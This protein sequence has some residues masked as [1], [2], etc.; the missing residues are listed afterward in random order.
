MA[1]S[2]ADKE[3]LALDLFLNTDKPQREICEIVG[4]T[5]KTFTEKKKKNRWDELKSAHTLTANKIISNIYKKL[6]EETE[7]DRLDADK[8][9]KLANSIEKLSD[10][11]ATISQIINVFKEFT[12]FTM[13]L[14]PE[15]AKK[16]NEFQKKFIDHKING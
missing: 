4:W 12:T 8:I 15:L 11:Q 16:I 7:K 1:L 10:R 6:S 3:A 14:N 5:E 13:E 2:R 9:I